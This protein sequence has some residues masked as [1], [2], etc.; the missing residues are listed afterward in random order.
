MF[1]VPAIQPPAGLNS[2]LVPKIMRVMSRLNVWIYRATG[3]FIG[4]TWRVGS[5]F[6]KGVPVCLLTT[7]G[8]KSNLPRTTP[9]L[10]LKDGTR[11]IVVASQGGLPQDPLWYGNL[12]AHPEVT[13]QIGWKK[14]TMRARPASA[15]ERALL[16]PRLVA[17][18]ADFA[19]YQS[20]TDRTIPVV[21]CESK[22]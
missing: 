11:V 21:I 17:L 7:L 6:R 10:Y 1:D 4:G 9:L 15:E 5:A 3:G 20:W 18:Y 16:W 12:V 2:P 14:R 13:V 8:R 19:Q 22:S